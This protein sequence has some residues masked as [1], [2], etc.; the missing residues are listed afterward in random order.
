[1]GILSQRGIGQT[2]GVSNDLIQSEV[3]SHFRTYSL[4]EKYLANP[5]KLQE[6][7]SFQIEPLSKK[8]LI[9]KYQQL[10]TFRNL[11]FVSE[12][13]FKILRIR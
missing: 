1:M 5:V 2:F 8:L 9:E 6:Q 3:M 4:L 10:I 7:M 11:L 13:L 12:F